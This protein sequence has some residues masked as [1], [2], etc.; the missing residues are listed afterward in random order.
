RLAS[1]RAELPPHPHE[2]ILRRLGRVIGTDHPASEAVYA[3]HMSLIQSPERLR[4]PANGKRYVPGVS[5]RGRV[6]HRALGRDHSGARLL[7]AV[8]WTLRKGKGFEGRKMRRRSGLALWNDE[9]PRLFR[10]A[11][12]GGGY[13]TV[14]LGVP[15]VP[16]ALP[17]RCDSERVW[18]PREC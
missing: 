1:E 3:A 12:A 14:P 6:G 7:H 17:L 2:H 15:R 4:V 11:R 13:V 9:P 18:P 16:Q 5:R 8:C 10:P